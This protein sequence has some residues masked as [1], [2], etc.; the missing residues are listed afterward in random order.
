MGRSGAFPQWLEMVDFAKVSFQLE[1][2]ENC[3]LPPQALLQ[4][5]RE[6]FGALQQLR[7]E[8]TPEQMAILQQLLLPEVSTD[9]VVQRLVQKPAP[10]FV[11]DPGLLQQGDYAQGEEIELS[12]VFFGRGI[13]ALKEFIGLLETVGNRGLFKGQ[14]RFCLR[15]LSSVDLNGDYTRLTKDQLTPAISPLSWWLEQQPDVSGSVQLNLVSPM[16]LISHGRPLFRASFLDILPFILRRVSHMVLSHGQMDMP[17]HQ[18]NLFDHQQIMDTA[19]QIAVE[20]NY[21]RWQDWRTLHQYE[22]KRP[23][24]G[25]AGHLRLSGDAVEEIAWLLQLGSLFNI[26]KSATYGCGHYRLLP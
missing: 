2:I 12:V 7:H 19:C 3:Y 8:G 5:R 15:S 26:G 11:I 21:L 9:P 10:P 6:L 13:P 23:L 22:R 18:H 14:G 24:G 4:L 25:L 16:R 17:L 1:L 20:E